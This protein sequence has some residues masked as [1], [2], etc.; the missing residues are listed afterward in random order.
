MAWLSAAQLEAMG[1]QALGD[2]VLISERASFYN[3]PRIRLGSH[4]RIDDFCVLSAGEHGI[5]IDNFDF[6]YVYGLFRLAGIVQQIYYRFFHGQTKDKRFA[7]FIM[8][9]KLLEQMALQ[10]IGKSTL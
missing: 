10:V 4:V 5:Q 8:M 3:C 9:N 2:H 1:F 7:Q 6:Y